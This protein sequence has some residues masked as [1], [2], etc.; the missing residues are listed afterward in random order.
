[1]CN[2]RIMNLFSDDY[3]PI[4][5]PPQCIDLSQSV[6]SSGINFVDQSLK[7]YY[8][9]TSNELVQELFARI[10]TDKF[11]L[12][13]MRFAERSY[14]RVSGL[15]FSIESGIAHRD[16]SS[17]RS[18]CAF[19]TRIVNK[20]IPASRLMFFVCGKTVIIPC[21]RMS[22][23]NRFAFIN[24]LNE[25]LK[26]VVLKS[27]SLSPL[28]DVNYSFSCGLD[29]L[30]EIACDVILSTS[31]M[32]RSI[33]LSAVHEVISLD[34]DPIII[35]YASRVGEENIAINETAITLARILKVPEIAFAH[36]M[37]EF[38]RN[39]HSEYYATYRQS[40]LAAL[41]TR[42]ESLYY[43]GQLNEVCNLNDAYDSL[44]KIHCED[45]SERE[46][47]SGRTETYIDLI[48]HMRVVNSANYDAMLC[49]FIKRKLLEYSKSVDFTKNEIG[50][51]LYFVGAHR[52]ATKNIGLSVRSGNAAYEWYEFVET[53]GSTHYKWVRIV[54]LPQV[55]QLRL[56]PFLFRYVEQLLNN[57]RYELGQVNIV[58]A[59]SA[60]AHADV[61]IAKLE[62][63]ASQAFLIM[64]RLS[65]LSVD[66]REMPVA[67]YLNDKMQ[68]YYSRT[69]F[70]NAADTDVNTIGVKNG[71]LVLGDAHNPESR[72]IRGY[73]QYAITKTTLG[74]I[75]PSNDK[76]VQWLR[77]QW[78]NY[79]YDAGVADWIMMYWSQALN[80]RVKPVLMLFLVAKG[81]HGKSFWSELMIDSLNVAEAGSSQIGG[82][83][84]KINPELFSG[85]DAN[86]NSHTTAA[87]KLVG[88][89][90][91]VVSEAG[92]NKFSTIVMKRM[93][94]QE[95][96][97]GRRLFKDEETVKFN[98]VMTYISNFDP[99]FDN[100]DYGTRRRIRCYRPKYKYVLHPDP[101]NPFEREDKP[102]FNKTIKGEQIY[103]SAMLTLMLE[104]HDRL[105]REYNGDI[106]RVP[107]PRAILDET[108]DT[109]YAAD[110]IYQ[111]AVENMCYISHEDY[112][113]SGSKR[114]DYTHPIGLIMRGFV[115][116][117]TNRPGGDGGKYSKYLEE[118]FMNSILEPFIV[119]KES[120]SSLVRVRVFSEQMPPTDID[121]RFT[122]YEW[123]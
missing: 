108:S 123:V 91:G 54:D 82:Y 104:A 48:H 40:I 73:H 36:N 69:A 84:C 51:M 8:K 22:Y 77:D 63:R 74:A 44:L 95:S 90:S 109:I 9:I 121:K 114:A 3:S 60:K 80:D 89:R 120:Y 57:V 18:L 50:E 65:K 55:L 5:T 81:G 15:T 96:Q 92:N 52:Y 13:T 116:W 20:L 26:T 4:L 122:R 47:L 119:K 87:M 118:S 6:S 14:N 101:A 1:M 67:G 24:Y 38:I 11:S 17:I 94:S 34:D 41:I 86:A 33:Y 66:I 61:A 45:E 83:G 25:C 19:V 7:R 97:T 72:L 113:A 110:Y 88:K 23:V 53:E 62:I 29:E 75:L 93:F 56:I 76:H 102:E 58:D 10:S 27:V 21:L 79:F 64:N 12:S 115:E 99:K 68:A 117:T 103:K 2:R 39:E 42:D 43:R 49:D 78:N 71:V 98:L 46:V 85:V 106:E 16:E 111:Y 35:D 37:I 107:I 105:Q 31:L 32:D 30:G 28:T 70:L 112:E 59:K 100:S